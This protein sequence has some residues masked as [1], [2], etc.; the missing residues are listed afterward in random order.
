MDG[1]PDAAGRFALGQTACW[2]RLGLGS[3]RRQCGTV[4][5]VVPPGLVPDLRRHPGIVIEE[6][7]SLPRDVESYVVREGEV[8][9]WPHEA[10][11]AATPA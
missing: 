11:A 1:A 9:R 5:A 2:T 6:G 10:L 3:T 4:E 7:H 8:T